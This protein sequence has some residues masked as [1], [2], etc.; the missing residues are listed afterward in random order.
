M[1]PD[2]PYSWVSKSNSFKQL[3]EVKLYLGNT[4]TGTWGFSGSISFLLC[5][6][7]NHAWI[8]LNLLAEI[9]FFYLEATWTSWLLRAL[10]QG[11][12]RYSVCYKSWL[13]CCSYRANLQACRHV[14]SAG[15]QVLLHEVIPHLY[16]R[17]FLMQKQTF[18][19]L[20]E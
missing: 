15:E 13:K 17:V 20:R 12:W 3:L 11:N 7:N 10:W 19:V 4:D 6:Y 8:E 16:Y 2:I 14:F 9:S 18:L 5:F 1:I